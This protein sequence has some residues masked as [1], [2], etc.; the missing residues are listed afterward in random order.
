MTRLAVLRAGYGAL[1]LAFAGLAGSVY[2]PTL[3]F[4]ALAL[5]IAAGALL[6]FSD[7]PIPKWAGLVLLAYFVVT[8]LVFLAATPITI[9]KGEGYFVN[10]APT[11]VAQESFSWLVLA[12][13][14]I[15]VGTAILASWEREVPVRILLIGALGGFVVVAALT[16]IL[17]PEIEPECATD[18]SSPECSGASARAK[19]EIERQGDMLRNLTTVSAAAGA[20]GMIWAAGRPD[21]YA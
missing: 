10:A 2:L 4:P 14:L 18:P 6:A 13:P 17:V 8:V 11:V 3:L 9:D 7:D 21:Q 12:A 1:G 19:A 5:S 20:A 16:V 15:L